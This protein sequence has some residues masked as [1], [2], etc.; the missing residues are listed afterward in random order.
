MD[1]PAGASLEWIVGLILGPAALAA[2]LTGVFTAYHNVQKAKLDRELQR[3]IAEWGL[4]KAAF[5][6]RFREEFATYKALWPALKVLTDAV[7]FEEDIMT[8][9]P[10]KMRAD[11]I[12]KAI[13][14]AAD[15]LH[16][17]G[18]YLPAEIRA[19]ADDIVRHATTH[20]TNAKYPALANPDIFK[21]PKSPSELRL[22]L[23][24][25]QELISRRIEM[26]P[27]SRTAPARTMTSTLS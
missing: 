14:P 7:A 15:A 13:R 8:T 2:V 27:E 1:L 26:A 5:D 3:Q 25:L 4:R 21:P 10:A 12:Q 23:A 9:L 20:H 19:L 24:E 16:E 22:Q 11:D 6:I 17:N 18:F